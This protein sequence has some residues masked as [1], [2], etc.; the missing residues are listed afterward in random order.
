MDWVKREEESMDWVKARSMDG[1][2]RGVWMGY[3]A[4]RESRLGLKRVGLG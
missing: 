3:K 1:I 2:K 4:R